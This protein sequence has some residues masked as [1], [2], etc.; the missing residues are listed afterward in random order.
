MHL[1]DHWCYHVDLSAIG[2]NSPINKSNVLSVLHNW[3]IKGT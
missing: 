2:P 1:L 3:D